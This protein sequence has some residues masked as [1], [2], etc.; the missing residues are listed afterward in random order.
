[1]GSATALDRGATT[2]LGQ[3]DADTAPQDLRRAVVDI[4]APLDAFRLMLAAEYG[5]ATLK[6]A[7]EINSYSWF[8]FPKSTYVSTYVKVRKGKVSRP[9]IPLSVHAAAQRTLK[10]L[11]DRVR[12]GDIGLVGQ[13]NNSPPIDIGRADSLIGKL[14]IFQQT[15]TIYRGRTR[16]RLYHNVFCVKH[17]VM[18]VVNSASKN[19]SATTATPL[20]EAPDSTIREAI[21]SVYDD[22]DKGG[23]RPNINQLVAAVLPRLLGYRP[24]SGNHIKNI[25]REKEFAGRRGKVGKRLT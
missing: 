2:N 24:P 5:K 6:F 13:L 11:C 25:G 20:E 7:D 9:K 15:L 12:E 8:Y 21:R 23:P 10:L 17:G 1:V 16:A 19:R 3:C 14:D 4:I 22:A 18:R